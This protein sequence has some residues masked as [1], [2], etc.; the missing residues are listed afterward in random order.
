MTMFAAAVGDEY[1]DRPGEFD[2]L[3][4][5]GQSCEVCNGCLDCQPG[6]PCAWCSRAER[7]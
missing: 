4:E 3:C 6:M 7:E 5:D 1:G 2:C